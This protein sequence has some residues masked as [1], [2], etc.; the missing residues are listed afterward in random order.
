MKTFA[1][2]AGLYVLSCTILMLSMLIAED[3]STGYCAGLSIVDCLSHLVHGTDVSVMTSGIVAMAAKSRKDWPSELTLVSGQELAELWNEDVVKRFVLDSLRYQNY[4][5]VPVLDCARLVM[6][7]RIDPFDEVE[8]A[9]PIRVFNRN[10]V[11]GIL[12]WIREHYYDSLPFSP[13]VI[14]VRSSVFDLAVLVDRKRGL[15]GARRM[16]I[17]T[18][19]DKGI[20]AGDGRTYSNYRRIGLIARDYLAGYPKLIRDTK[21][22]SV[23]CTTDRLHVG[24]TSRCAYGRALAEY[25][26]TYPGAI[27]F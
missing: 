21:E 13:S 23:L 6:P 18:S 12:E 7:I 20:T 14:V 5:E 8:F 1:D 2:L 3:V 16:H 11:I 26:R 19:T 9:E 25:E 15:I 27:S 10:S 17:R 24:T 4:S 22:Q